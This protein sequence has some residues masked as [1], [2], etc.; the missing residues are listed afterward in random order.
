[1]RNFLLMLLAM[2][3]SVAIASAPGLPGAAQSERLANAGTSDRWARHSTD[4]Q[5]DEAVRFG[6]LSNGMRYALMRNTTPP[7]QTSLRLRIDAGSLMET[8]NQLG[9]AHFV[10]H[11]T[12]NGTRSTPK[13]DMLRTL[14]RLGVAFG[15]DVN[16]STGYEQTVYQIELPLTGEDSLR[17]ALRILREQVSEALFDPN[18]IEAEREVILSEERLRNTPQQRTLREQ[19]GFIAPDQYIANRFPI[20]DPIIIRSVPRDI[21]VNFYNSYYRPSRTTLI[22]VG[23]FDIDYMEDLVN[24]TFSDWVPRAVDGADPAPASLM[25]RNP[26]S[27]I[28]VEAGTQSFVQLNWIRSVDPA[29]DSIQ[30]RTNIIRRDLGLAVLTRRLGEIS[31]QSNPALLT[32]NVFTETIPSSIERTVVAGVFNRGQVIRALQT[33]EQEQRRLLEFGV[34]LEELELEIA[35]MRSTLEGI[36]AQSS[37]FPSSILANRI[38]TAVNL[39]MTVTSPKTDLEL[40]NRAV[41]GVTTDHILVE[42]QRAFSGQGPMALVVSPENIE[43]GADAV[44]AVIS[45]SRL[46][47]LSPRQTSAPAIWSYQNFGTASVPTSRRTFPNI[48]ATVHSFPNG[49]RLIVKTT[50]F[51]EDQVLISVSTG[52]G[53]LG[54]PNDLESPVRLAPLT[55]A[56]GG[57]G[58]LTADQLNSALPG[59]AQSVAFST[60]SDSF[61]LTSATRP[62]DIQV[63]MQVLA[64]YLTDP[65]L[66]PEP[67]E[68]VKALW[69]QIVAQQMATPEGAF[70][71]QSSALLV[72]GDSRR[73]FPTVEGVSGWTNE[74]LSTAIRSGLAVGPVEIVVVG[75]VAEEAAVASVA[76]TFGALPSRPGRPRPLAGS[77]LMRFPAG[78]PLPIRLRH[79]GPS[80]Q[81]LAFVAWPTT[82][83]IADRTE[84]RLAEVLG[85]VFALRANDE[86]RERQ[87]LSYSPRVFSSSSRTFPGY[88]LIEI[89]AEVSPERLND[90]FETIETIARSLQDTLISD[91]ELNRARIPEIE[92][93]RRAQASN[94]YWLGELVSVGRDP[95]SVVQ[96]ESHLS[97]FESITPADIQSAARRFLITERAWRAEVRA[98]EATW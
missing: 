72:D 26:S 36:N 1:M 5:L 19:L 32:G 20:G 75:D 59:R 16:A 22:A 74:Q 46:T 23:D 44:N 76:S 38:L 54:L 50:S 73:L 71:V 29:P 80:N 43:G 14:Q 58:G 84:A 87:R 98:A 37:T 48:G 8:D 52:S 49:V 17:A 70:N 53:E 93:I 6:V 35:A 34:T 40:F 81:A 45:A 10:E 55:F 96:I 90:F 67:F 77:D 56:S 47:A 63:Q 94:E 9:V 25:Q 89:R 57:L 69:P 78:T 65:G 86:L 66:R 41:L 27:A 21:I 64:A 68:Q 62:A 18:D 30:K 91:D 31:R 11:M 13:N 97:D 15:P 60:L 33:I 4:V 88:G 3:S 12:F 83:A 7:G 28:I 42:I 95:A 2:T 61:L 24:S 92:R 51:R 82:D 85:R 39:D 79:T